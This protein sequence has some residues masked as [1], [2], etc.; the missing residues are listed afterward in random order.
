MSKR[1]SIETA[2]HEITISGRN[3]I[4]V[5]VLPSQH[6]LEC[7]ILLSDGKTIKVSGLVAVELIKELKKP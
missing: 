1:T 6:S 5:D 2:Q 7:E 3:D 4:V